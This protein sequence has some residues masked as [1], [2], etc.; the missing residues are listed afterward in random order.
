[1]ARS[2]GAV[3]V[4]SW[5]EDAWR[6]VTLAGHEPRDV[7]IGL[8]CDACLE[9]HDCLLERQLRESL[10]LALL[11]VGEPARLAID[12]SAFRGARRARRAA[13]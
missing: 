8:P 10:P 11:D 1:M 5:E 9:R 3:R 6:A 12:C 4:R 7:A 2:I 13:A